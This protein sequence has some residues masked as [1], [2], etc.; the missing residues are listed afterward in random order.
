MKQNEVIVC[1]LEL[2]YRVV[3]EDAYSSIIS[4]TLHR[5]PFS[6]KEKAYGMRVAFGVLEHL[7]LLRHYLDEL[8]KKKVNKKLK[9]LLLMALY[10]IEFM[11]GNA[12]HISVNAY[13]NVTKTIYPYAKNFVNAILREHIR[14]GTGRFRAET[15]EEQAILLS[16]PIELANLFRDAYGEEKALELMRA[17]QS[18]AALHLR[19]NLTKCTAQDLIRNLNEAG[20]EAELSPLSD[21]SVVVRSLQENAIQDLD[22]YKQGFFYIQD[23]ASVLLADALHIEGDE[24]VLDLCSAPGGKALAIAEDIK[25]KRGRGRVVACDIYENKL[26]LIR[27]NANRLGLD[28]EILW[29]DATVLNPAFSDAFDLVLADV[30][31]SGFGIIRKKIE[32]KYKKLEHNP[33]TMI[34]L[35]DEIL[36][37]ASRYVK[38]GGRLVYSTC[39]MNPEEN[40]LRVESFLKEDRRFLFDYIDTKEYAS[41]SG[42]QLFTSEETD[43]FYIAILKRIA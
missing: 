5:Q 26:Q 13:V 18:K 14:R 21:R 16:H 6:P 28:I 22:A 41:E 33:E 19:V 11:D 2:L 36:R 23:V 39:T 37:T 32:I 20:V 10:E 29:N 30:P 27:D 17:N 3:H 24:K 31:C 43:G 9:L 34:K 7:I 25:R 40:D 42:L 12:D 15:F 35:Q 38:P 4:S 1:V 8:A